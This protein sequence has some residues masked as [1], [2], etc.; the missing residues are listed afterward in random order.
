MADY[1]LADWR[2]VLRMLLP[3]LYHVSLLHSLVSRATIRQMLDDR[4][5]SEGVHKSTGSRS[6]GSMFVAN[7][8]RKEMDH[9]NG[10]LEASTDHI[11]QVPLQT[12]PVGL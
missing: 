2:K 10:D 5:A 1:D 8:A 11:V 12:L 6:A 9:K 3:C 4:L 7:Y